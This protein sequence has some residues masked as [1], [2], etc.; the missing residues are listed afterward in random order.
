V[1]RHQVRLHRVHQRHQDVGHRIQDVHRL[2]HQDVGHQG[3]RDDRQDQ[4]VRQGQDEFRGRDVS[5]DQDVHLGQV[6]IQTDQQDEIRARCA[7]QEEAEWGDHWPTWGQVVAE[8][9]DRQDERL[10][11]SLVACPEEFRLGDLVEAQDVGW[12]A[13]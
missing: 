6:G 8:L 9:D 10:V 7:D 3:H 4:D 13:D 2:D 1:D 12:A 5:Q 11:A